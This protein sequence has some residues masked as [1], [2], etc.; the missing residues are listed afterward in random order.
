MSNYVVL[1]IGCLECMEETEV[2]AHLPECDAQDL[3]E[4][5]LRDDPKTK[6]F[7]ALE[8][9]ELGTVVRRYQNA[10]SHNTRLPQ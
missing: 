6:R 9:P 2:L 8:L 4:Y 5:L 7:V 10:R 3:L 1:E